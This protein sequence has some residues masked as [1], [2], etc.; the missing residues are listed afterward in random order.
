MNFNDKKN[1]NGG[2]ETKSCRWE[3][4]LGMTLASIQAAQNE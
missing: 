4:T 1:L 2:H 3:K